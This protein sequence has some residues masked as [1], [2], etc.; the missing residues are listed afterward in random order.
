MQWLGL[1]PEGIAFSKDTLS[2]KGKAVIH[3]VVLVS[4]LPWFQQDGYCLAEFEAQ[5]NLELH[6]RV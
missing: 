5:R 4:V 1:R 3:T 2:V 6:F